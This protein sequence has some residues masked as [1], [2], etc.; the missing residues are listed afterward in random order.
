MERQIRR[1]AFGFL[2]LFVVLMA[3]V[4]YLQVFAADELANNPANKRLLIQEYDVQRG[5]ILARDEQTVLAGSRATEGD[6]KYRRTY[7]VG[8][9]YGH[10]T[11]YYSVVFGRSNL[12][13]SYNEF[14]A[15]RATE[16]LPQKLVDEIL[17]RPQRGATVV[18]TIDPALQQ[19]VR[20][21]LGSLP[22]AVVALDPR[23]GEVLATYANPTFDPSPL[24]SHEPDVVREAWRS[25]IENPNKPLLSRAF[26]ELYPPGSTFKLVTAAAALENGMR[27]DTRID[28]PPTYTPPQTTNDIE[29]FGGS[30]CLGGAPQI[31]LAQALQV[32]CNVTFAKIGVEFLGQEKLVEQAERFGLNGDVDFDVPFVEGQIPPPEAFDDDQPGL[33]FSAIGQQS[34]AVNPLQMAIIAGAIANGGVQMRPRLVREIRDPSGRVV[35]T[36]DPEVFAEPMSAQSAAEL[37]A[38]MV[39]VVEDGTAT[40]AQIPGVRVAGKTG[41]AQHPGGDPHAWFVAFAPADAPEI[42]VAVMVLNGG[43]LGSDATGGRVAAPI[44]KAVLEAALGG[45]T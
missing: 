16:L 12:E 31:T 34:V 10:I 43:D 37:T 19:L 2:A 45:Q 17:G 29:N 32:S 44:A 20:D 22:G 13:S 3:Q 40:V 1:L 33:A 24:A 28:N 41:T 35:K 7:P 23:T 8:D 38:M 27:P 11:G 14:L 26:Q 39:S 5:Q 42:A 6:L 9:L 30:H 36:Y 18:T 15:G 4:N 25:L 21:R